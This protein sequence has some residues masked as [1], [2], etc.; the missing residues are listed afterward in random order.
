MVLDPALK[1]AS[2]PPADLSE[3]VVTSPRQLRL[4][5]QQLGLKLL[6][7]RPAED[8]EIAS[9]CLPTD[10]GET[11]KVEGLR[12]ALASFG[13]TLLGVPTEFDQPS[14]LRVQLQAKLGKPLPKVGQT[15][16]GVGFLAETDHEVVC[17]PYDDH[18]TL[19]LA[20]PPVMNPEVQHIVKEHIRQ[21]R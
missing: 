21:E 11:Q 6:P 7:R 3:V 18:L 2:Q 17:V 13:S 20:F 15:S 4:D 12:R 8:R 14:F 1:H 9:P 16:S 19:G 5:R 10:V